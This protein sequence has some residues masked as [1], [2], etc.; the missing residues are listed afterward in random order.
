MDLAPSASAAEVR[1]GD[2][3]GSL[4]VL[5]QAPFGAKGDT[6]AAGFAP[7]LEYLDSVLLCR[8]L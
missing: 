2:E 3:G 4:V 8:I 6:D 7:G 5:F 1:A